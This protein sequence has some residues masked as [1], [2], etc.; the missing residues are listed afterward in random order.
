MGGAE[1]ESAAISLARLSKIFQK[2]PASRK[3]AA[4]RMTGTGFTAQNN[5]G[6]RKI[7]FISHCESTFHLA[8]IS[9]EKHWQSYPMFPSPTR[10]TLT[11]QRLRLA[12]PK[13]IWKGILILDCF[14]FPIE[15]QGTEHIQLMVRGQLDGTPYKGQSHACCSKRRE[16][17]IPILGL[18]PAPAPRRETKRA[19]KSP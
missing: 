11:G 9:T 4:S 18:P 17:G 5:T 12:A 10:C 13:S 14:V 15:F 1:H 7:T 16:A 2:P 8:E 6:R 19:W 3:P